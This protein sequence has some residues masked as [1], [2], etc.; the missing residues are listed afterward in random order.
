MH[1]I[2]RWRASEPPFADDCKNKKKDSDCEG[3][4]KSDYCKESSKWYGYMKDNCKK[5]CGLCAVK[6]T[7]CNMNY[8]KPF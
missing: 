1:L 4:K 3:W 5:S 7:F 8:L 6:G 2:Y